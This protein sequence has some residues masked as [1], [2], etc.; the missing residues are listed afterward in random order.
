MWMLSLRGTCRAPKMETVGRRIKDKTRLQNRCIFSIKLKRAL[1]D[2]G[3]RPDLMQ[4]SKKLL[5]TD[6]KIML[7]SEE[8]IKVLKNTDPA[9]RDALPLHIM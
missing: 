3:L 4:K 7:N 6:A 2:T 9:K 8:F 1:V 5:E